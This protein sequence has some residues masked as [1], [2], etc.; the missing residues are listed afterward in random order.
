[1]CGDAAHSFPPAGGFGM[2]TGLQDAHSLAFR[3][4]HIIKNGLTRDQWSPILDEYWKERKSHASL[5]LAT[6]LKFYQNSLNIASKLGMNLKWI[7]F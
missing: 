5:N 1:M 3:L 2:N 7:G 6:A 4:S